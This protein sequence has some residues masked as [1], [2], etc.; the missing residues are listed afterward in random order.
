MPSK[1]TEAFIYSAKGE[2]DV[3]VISTVLFINH[4]DFK[5]RASVSALDTAAELG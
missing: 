1:S 2:N 3:K 4:E 5:T